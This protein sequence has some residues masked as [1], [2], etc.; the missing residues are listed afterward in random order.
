MGW[1][2]RPETV[3]GGWV[4]FGAGSNVVGKIMA[5]FFSSLLSAFSGKDKPAQAAKGVEPVAYKDCL[6][7]PAPIAEGGQYRLAGRIEKDVNGETLVRH[8]IR[9]DMFSSMEDAVTF[10]VRKAEQI[11]DQNGSSLFS[12]GQSSRSA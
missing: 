3:T 1:R 6:I 2:F 10:T 8:V 11:I 7:Y 12:D 9:A 4:R 5:S